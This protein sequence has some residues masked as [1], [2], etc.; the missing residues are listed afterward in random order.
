MTQAAFFIFTMEEDAKKGITFL[1]EC[2]PNGE[3]FERGF[4]FLVPK[5]RKRKERRFSFTLPSQ[6]RNAFL[7][8]RSL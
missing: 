8:R 4:T 2:R 7:E 3:R 5:K 1:V 6:K